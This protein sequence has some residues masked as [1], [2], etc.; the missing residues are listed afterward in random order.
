MREAILVMSY[1]TPERLEDVEAYYTHIRRGNPPPEHLLEELIERYEAVGGPTELNRIT[2]L[3]ARALA[4]ELDR[5]GLD[6]RV[7]VGF[8]HVPPFIADAVADMADDDVEAAVGL[9]LAPHY[10]L[11]SIAEYEH[12]AEQARPESMEIDLIRSW[13]DHPAYVEWLA[14]RL[15]NTLESV[16]GEPTVVFTAHS[17]PSR[18]L[19]KGDPYPDQLRENCEQVAERA[20]VERWRFAYQSA[21]RTD[22]P[23]LGPDVLDVVEELADAGEDAIV[24]QA[25]GFVAD[26]LEILYDLDIEVRDAA[27]ARGMSYARTPMPNVDP[28]FVSALADLVEKRLASIATSSAG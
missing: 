23:W 5:R 21:G 19:E 14:T 25:I 27:R 16:D 8:K 9:V 28:D 17:V 22:E 24:V 3:Q 18:V 20:G 4:D 10:S 15:E 11:R 13:H 7:Y 12:Y 1:G 2:R 6:T 26:H